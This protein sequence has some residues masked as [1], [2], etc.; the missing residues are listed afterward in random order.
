MAFESK[1]AS[2]G[3]IGARSNSSLLNVTSMDSYG[4][5]GD[6]QKNMLISYSSC[7]GKS[8]ILSYLGLNGKKMI[9]QS[10]LVDGV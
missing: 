5:L 4:H 8:I 10:H 9:S 3:E 6:G 7:V 2:I 1:K